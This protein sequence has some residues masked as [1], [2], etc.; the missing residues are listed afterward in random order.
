MRLELWAS[1]LDSL[2]SSLVPEITF[3]CSWPKGGEGPRDCRGKG[4]EVLVEAGTVPCSPLH[5]PALVSQVIR[6]P[7]VPKPLH[8][9]LGCP[10][11]CLRVLPR[12]PSS[13]FPAS[14]EHP[15]LNDKLVLVPGT[16]C[17]GWDLGRWGQT[18]REKAVR[19]RNLLEH[20][21]TGMVHM[22]V[23]WCVHTGGFVVPWLTFRCQR[24]VRGGEFTGLTSPILSCSAQVRT[25]WRVRRRVR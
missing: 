4:P 19:A 17:L 23:R 10:D 1:W 3:P 11:L 15:A 24:G 2:A 7:H 21:C 25:G 16:H 9:H 13:H 6:K 18:V 22:G 8:L 12:L 14:A 5:P 20:I